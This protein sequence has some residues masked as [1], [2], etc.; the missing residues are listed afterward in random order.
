MRKKINS[1]FKVS[2]FTIA[3]LLGGNAM[4]QNIQDQ[5]KAI[6]GQFAEEVFVNKDL[7]GLDK[8]LLEDYILQKL[9]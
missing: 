6:I 8:Y 2:F 1:I 3:V 9:V 5:N 4:A 7:S